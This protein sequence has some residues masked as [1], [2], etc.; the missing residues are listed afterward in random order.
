MGSRVGRPATGS[1][2]PAHTSAVTGRTPAG[3]RARSRSP[4]PAGGPSGSGSRPPGRRSWPRRTRRPSAGAG[5]PPRGRRCSRT[6]RRARSSPRGAPRG[7]AASSLS[8]CGA[9]RPGGRRPCPCRRTGSRCCTAGRGTPRRTARTARGPAPRRG[10]HPR[11]RCSTAPS[12]HARPRR[13]TYPATRDDGGRPGT[14]PSLPWTTVTV[15]PRRSPRRAT[16]ALTAAALVLTTVG[17][18]AVPTEAGTSHR[19]SWRVAPGVTYRQWHF[20]SPAGPQRVHVLDVNP[21]RP[22]VSLGYRTN[23]RLQV[24]RP[25]SRIVASDPLAV[26]GTN[27]NYFD[28]SGTG[29]PLGVGRNRA[30][31]VQHAPSS[32]WTNAFY[33]AGDGSYHV[34]TVSLT[35]HLAQHPTWPV[36]GLN[37]PHARSNAI[38]VYT[39]VWGRASGRAVVDDRR[40]PVREVHVNDGIVRQ[41]SPTLRK[42]RPFHGLLLIGLGRGAQLLKTLEVGSELDATWALDPRPQMAITGSQVLLQGGRVVATSDHQ[43]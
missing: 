21:R 9:G 20:T 25:T 12:L 40:T 14:I 39:P 4:V 33:Q 10:C 42:G 19:R 1:T 23:V 16:R 43:Q 2:H 28:I 3:T 38:T 29:A 26:G 32:G 22:G 18:A 6:P 30:H 7:G 34:G 5:G 35:A 15:A 11:R 13:T 37:L 41:N 27:G 31:G 36:T 17:L 8:R 24:R